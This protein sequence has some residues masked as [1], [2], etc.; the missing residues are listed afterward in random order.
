M[1][2]TCEANT[3]N[4]KTE[5]VIDNEFFK[6]GNL[7]ELT[8]IDPDENEKMVRRFS[9]EFMGDLTLSTSEEVIALLGDIRGTEVRLCLKK[10]NLI[11]R[12]S[13]TVKE[14]TIIDS[15]SE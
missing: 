2:A 14:L 15:T 9:D 10:L 8:E 13:S 1:G 12:A 11:T 7:H 5:I 6:N 4:P 3:R